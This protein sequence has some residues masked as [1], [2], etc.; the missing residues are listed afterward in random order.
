[1]SEYFHANGK[2]R[3]R[4]ESNEKDQTFER[5]THDESGKLVRIE[6]MKENHTHGLQ[7]HVG[8]NGQREIECWVRGQRKDSLAACGGKPKLDADGSETIRRY[9]ENG[10]VREEFRLVDGERDGA[11]KSFDRK[12]RLTATVTYRQ[13]K[14]AS[15]RSIALD[16]EG[17]IVGERLFENDAL[18]VE[19]SYYLNG[20]VRE[21]S[22]REGDRWL[23]K[24]YYDNGKLEREVPYRGGGG[25]YGRRYEGIEKR[26][27]PDGQ[28]VE[29]S[30]YRNGRLE[31]TSRRF[32]NGTLSA[33]S[34]YK[35]G[36]LVSETLYDAQG[37]VTA[38]TEYLPDGSR[39]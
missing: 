28:L 23:L 11:Y 33:K 17:R 10:N 35:D 15:G 7:E 32:W 37:R 22:F 24:T 29:E 38:S 19:R 16:D 20:K 5:R 18:T 3:E 27:D 26:Y 30:E 13:G 14:P 21:E 34:T 6:R 9:W 8:A 25:R 1:M 2:L 39:K 31:G 4:T 36:R 12:G